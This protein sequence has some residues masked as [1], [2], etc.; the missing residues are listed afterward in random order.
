M[1]V[2]SLLFAC[3]V[4]LVA[5]FWLGASVFAWGSRIEGRPASFEAGSTGGY[6]IWHDDSGFHLRTTDP[7]G[8]ESHFTGT[9]TTNGVFHDL[10]AIRAE[11]D[12]KVEQVGDGTIIFDLH[13]YSG[14][15]GFD[16]DVR[17]GDRVTFELKRDHNLIGVDHIF[18]GEDGVH[19]NHNPFTVN[20]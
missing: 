18:L 12:D 9:L 2:K 14:I 4:A 16:F 8:V 17:G 20:R 19:P 11:Q 15:D 1:T 10:T 13:T 6:Y 7:E 5:F 3:A